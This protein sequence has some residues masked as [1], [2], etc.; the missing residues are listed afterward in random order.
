[1]N[2]FEGLCLSVCLFGVQSVC[3]GYCLL[4]VWGVFLCLVKQINVPIS[5]EMTFIVAPGNC[6]LGVCIC[7]CFCSYFSLFPCLGRGGFESGVCCLLQWGEYFCVWASPELSAC[8]CVWADTFFV[9]LSVSHCA[10]ACR[11]LLV[12]ICQGWDWVSS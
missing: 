2:L 4:C 7:T 11:S 9:C 10:S 1:M 6:Q 8:C 12:C 5:I 3:F